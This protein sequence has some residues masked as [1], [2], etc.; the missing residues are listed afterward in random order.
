MAA[1]ARSLLV[2]ALFLAA[3][4]AALGS[5]ERHSI[6]K[7]DSM[8]GRHLHQSGS[9]NC[10]QE[11]IA[12][13]STLAVANG[14]LSALADALSSKDPE[15]AAIYIAALTTGLVLDFSQGSGLPEDCNTTALVSDALSI[16]VD[17]LISISGYLCG[18]DTAAGSVALDVR[19]ARLTL[20]NAGLEEQLGNNVTDI[21]D[22]G[23]QVLAPDLT[24][25]VK[26]F[27]VVCTPVGLIT[28]D[29]TGTDYTADTTFDPSF[30]DDTVID[31]A[32]ALGSTAPF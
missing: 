3:S 14:Y 4:S 6:P 10:S 26:S 9:R 13:N 20:N 31:L 28:D 25:A 2:L 16:L 11:P 29:S 18:E 17:A 12:L 19:N 30:I 8:H 15:S 1:F 22:W 5:A 32:K 7:L 24:D 23:V 27:L 21:I